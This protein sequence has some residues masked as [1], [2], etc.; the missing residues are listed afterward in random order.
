MTQEQFEAFY[1]IEYPK[2]V[3]ILVLLRATIEEAE[4][5]AQ[6]AMA[7]FIKRS[8]TAEAPRHSASYVRRAAIRFFIKERQRERERLQREPRSGYLITETHIDDQMIALEDEQ[9]IEHMLECLTSTQ[10]QVI[11]LVMDGLPTR[12]IAEELGKSDENIRQHLKNGRDRLKLHPEIASLAPR[13]G[14]SHVR[15]GVRSTVTTPEPR[16]EEVQ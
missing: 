14:Q 8:K 10:R 15:Q 1:T 16:K 2:L 6:N 7:D 4:V 11:R 9:C 12:E 5:A 3:K 13:Q